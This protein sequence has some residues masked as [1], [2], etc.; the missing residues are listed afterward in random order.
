M[1]PFWAV[2]RLTEDEVQRIPGCKFSCETVAK[3]L[4]MVVVGTDDLTTTWQVTLPFL[5]NSCDLPIGAE[6]VWQCAK[7][8]EKAKKARN[9][10]A[11]L[12]MGP[13]RGPLERPFREL[14]CWNHSAR[15]M[16]ERAVQD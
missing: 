10:S 16:Q 8:N 4:Q 12:R 13:A 9:G 6:L 1:N 14:W 15:K 5:T 7:K 11:E 2:W 3:Q